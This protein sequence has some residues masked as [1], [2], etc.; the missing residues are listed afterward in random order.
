MIEVN[1]V[2]S[3]FIILIIKSVIK[4]KQILKLFKQLGYNYFYRSADRAS[5]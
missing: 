4:N 1:I 2:F 3:E 5:L